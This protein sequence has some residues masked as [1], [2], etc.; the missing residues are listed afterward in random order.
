MKFFPDKKQNLLSWDYFLQVL[1][2]Q[3]IQ[4]FGYQVKGILLYLVSGISF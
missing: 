3:D 1:D 2:Y 4:V